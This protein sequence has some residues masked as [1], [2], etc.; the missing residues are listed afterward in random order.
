MPQTLALFRLVCGVFLCWTAVVFLL[1]RS[2]QAGTIDR[3]QLQALLPAS[4][5]AGE[6]DPL[7]AVRPVF[8]EADGKRSLRG[9]VFE[10]V[11]FE[12]ARGYS[13]KPINLLITLAVDGTFL[14]VQLLSH[15][16]PIFLNERGNQLLVEFARQYEGLTVRHN[17]QIVAAKEPSR[18]SDDSALLTGVTQGTV[19][20]RAIDRAVLQSAIAVAR[21]R[22]DQEPQAASV[23]TRRAVNDQYSPMS[24]HE[25]IEQRWVVPF[26]L[27]ASDIEDRFKGTR[28]SAD[29]L[30]GP[31]AA[32]AQPALSTTTVELWLSLLSAAPAGRNL[33][34]QPGWDYVR[35]IA[36]S[37]EQVVM[38]LERG[39]MPLVDSERMRK[40]SS[41]TRPGGLNMILHQADRKYELVEID[42]DHVVR[43][44]VD[45]RNT[46]PAARVRLFRTQ[47]AA[48]FDP[49]LPWDLVLTLQ[50]RYGP[51]VLQRVRVEWPVAFPARSPAA[52]VLSKEA[53]PEVVTRAASSWQAAWRERAFDLAV[54]GFAIIVL[55][56]ALARPVWLS[57]RPQR[58]RRFRVVYLL[59]TLVF[60]GWYA[61]GQLSIVNLTSS[62]EA[63]RA[64]DSLHFLLF[65]PITICLWMFVLITLLVWG[66]G[67][68]CGWLCPFGALQELLSM[69]A[70]AVQIQPIRFTQALDGRLKL[71]KYFVLVGL[72]CSAASLSS[73]T[74]AGVE[75]EP[76]KTAISMGFVRTWPYVAWA[77]I[78]ALASVFVFRG[79]C[80]YVCPLGAAMA[81]IGSIRL[82]DW[83]PRKSEC[84]TPC[85]T[86]RHRCDYQ[87][88]APTGSVDYRE[89]F[90][91]LECVEIYQDPQR[92]LPLIRLHKTS[93]QISSP[94]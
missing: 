40:Q 47:N 78:C 59:F 89:C 85:Q 9:Y 91:C 39:P 75:V 33:L 64:G 52:Q 94:S 22:I 70:R 80:R 19:S 65:D 74:E 16:E 27:R 10:S 45:L 2:A 29:E 68:F 63:V 21:A 37:G 79:Y 71:I 1:G 30:L 84:G 46:A 28:A 72:V 42:F 43:W 3:A 53:L 12:P 76:F 31:Y 11:D 6:L 54:L 66:R 56:V 81:V 86:C 67:T 61:Q 25:L 34:D 73:W 62:I 36:A 87:A 35:S 41:G 24:W 92:C 20:V 8:Q 83:I 13:G 26:Q 48:D 49:N 58:L 7:L 38:A 57:A 5:I 51:D 60:I 90:Q 77:S 44:P 82:L 17:I 50:R 55:S 93:A 18:K 4:L 14:G 88:I 15:R 32:V 69:L 23:G